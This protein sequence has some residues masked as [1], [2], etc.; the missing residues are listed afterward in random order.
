[1]LGLK[2]SGNRFHLLQVLLYLLRYSAPH[3]TRNNLRA[4]RNPGSSALYRKASI[5][6]ASWNGNLTDTRFWIRSNK[7][8]DIW[9]LHRF[10]PILPK[11]SRYADFLWVL[12]RFLV[13]FFI[14]DLM[15]YGFT[16]HVFFMYQK[17]RNWR[18]CLL[19]SVLCPLRSIHYG[20]R[21]PS[22]EADATA[23]PSSKHTYTHTTSI[24]TLCALYGYIGEYTTHGQK[25]KSHWCNI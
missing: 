18:P 10:L 19:N 9:T 4:N 13:G 12:R 15:Q 7:F 17:P 16:L 1:M 5:Y 21:H 11:F 8:P 20:S 6:A 22:S 24:I 25:L 14:F 2:D 23:K 3:V